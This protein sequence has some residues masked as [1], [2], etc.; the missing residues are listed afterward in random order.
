MIRKKTGFY[1][2]GL[3]KLFQGELLDSF[4]KDYPILGAKLFCEKYNLDIN[5]HTLTCFALKMNVSIDKDILKQRTKKTYT[6]EKR[7][8]AGEKLSKDK[9]IYDYSD[10]KE[11]LIS[12]FNKY[13]SAR[14]IA[15][16]NNL[17]EY[18]IK[19]HLYMWG[20]KL[21]RNPK[22]SEFTSTDLDFI[23]L[24]KDDMTTKEISCAIKKTHIQV[25]KKMNKLYPDRNWKK[26]RSEKTFIFNTQDYP[27]KK[28]GEMTD[29][30]VKMK[31]ILDKYN[32][33]YIY[34]RRV[35]F[36]KQVKFPDFNLNNKLVIECDGRHWHKSILDRII[37]DNLFSNNGFDIIHFD[38]HE[39]FKKTGEVELC[40]LQK[41]R[42]LNIQVE[43]IPAI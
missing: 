1:N 35:V 38:D 21:V 27:H 7:K 29:I 37:R 9:T 41:L 33:D 14:K 20:Y 17:N 4:K 3:N 8:L 22:Y 32:L 18:A 23:S 30:E 39:I 10:K 19:K 34:D 26:L 2:Y 13:K 11:Y 15:A 28:K 25:I 43:K 24:H 16:V 6:P 31:E 36:D 40:I 5:P 42:V 12:E